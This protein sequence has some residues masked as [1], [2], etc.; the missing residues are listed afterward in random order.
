MCL[1]EGAVQIDLGLLGLD[2]SDWFNEKAA[3]RIADDAWP[4]I[5]EKIKNSNYFQGMDNETY[6]KVILWAKNRTK[7]VFD[8]DE[9]TGTPSRERKLLREAQESDRESAAMH[10]WDYDPNSTY[11]DASSLYNDCLL[12]TSPSPRDR[13]KS[14]MPSSA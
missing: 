13:Q 8:V 5:K 2:E 3:L 14:R 9:Y 6:N 4:K 12:Y 11:Y 10:G 1:A 7:R